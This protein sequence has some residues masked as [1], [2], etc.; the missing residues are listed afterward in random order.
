MHNSFP[1]TYSTINIWDELK[2]KTEHSSNFLCISNVLYSNFKQNM[3]ITKS[4]LYQQLGAAPPDPHTQNL[5]VGIETPPGIFF[6][7]PLAKLQSNVCMRLEYASHASQTRPACIPDGSYI[8]R[9]RA[10][11]LIKSCCSFIEKFALAWMRLVRVLDTSHTHTRCISLMFRM[12]F[13]RILDASC[14]HSRCTRK[15]PWSWAAS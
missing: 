8:W 6:P 15:L 3:M 14:M 11:K 4:K 1:Y 13:A 7:T 5:P 10:W 12:H 2:T 9:E